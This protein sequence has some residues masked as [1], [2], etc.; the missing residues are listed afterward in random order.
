MAKTVEKVREKGLSSVGGLMAADPISRKVVDKGVKKIDSKLKSKGAF[1]ESTLSKNE[2]KA[3]AEKATQEES[4]ALQ[5][6]KE[7]LNLLEADD[8][9]GR[10]KLLRKTGGRQSLI[11]SR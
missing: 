7:Q 11:A 1:L 8:V 4:I 10:R 6:Q 5:S 2:D 3:A 9:A